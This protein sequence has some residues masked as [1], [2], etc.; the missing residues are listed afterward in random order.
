M[1]W[2]GDKSYSINSFMP[3]S[4]SKHSTA[5][6]NENESGVGRLI[7]L[8]ITHLSRMFWFWP[9]HKWTY[10]VSFIAAPQWIQEKQQN[11]HLT[12][13][14]IF[15]KFFLEKLQK[16]ERIDTEPFDWVTDEELEKN[17]N[18]SAFL[19]HEFLANSKMP[20]LPSRL[21]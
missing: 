12:V 16:N 11:W 10:G 4:E 1:S 8:R 7:C 20:V 2:P 19:C 17:C 3:G 21:K 14:R 18:K 9:G 13:W 6:A 5:V 15:W